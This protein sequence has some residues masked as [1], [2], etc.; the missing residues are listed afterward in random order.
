MALTSA[1]TRAFQ[2]RLLSLFSASSGDSCGRSSSL[3]TSRTVLGAKAY[4]YV[5]LEETDY[6]DSRLPVLSGRKS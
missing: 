3:D 4:S 1:P 5:W 2:Y 6:Q